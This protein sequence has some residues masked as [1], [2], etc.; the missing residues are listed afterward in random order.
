MKDYLFEQRHWL[1]IEWPPGHAPNL[2][3]AEGAWYDV[4]GREMANL[5]PDCMEEAV[6]RFRRSDAPF[7]SISSQKCFA[8]PT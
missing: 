7:I 5:C 1:T 8:M 6:A 4:K 3:P 2:N